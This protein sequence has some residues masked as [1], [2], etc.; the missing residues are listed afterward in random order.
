MAETGSLVT[1]FVVGLLGGVHCIGM[2]G[3][4]VSTLTLS[5]PVQRKTSLGSLF[6]FQ[7]AYNSG[8]ILGYVCVGALLGALG[9]LLLES[10]HLG[11]GQRVLYGIAALFMILLGLYLGGWWPGLAKIERLGV[12]VWRL[13]KPIGR[14]FLPVRS[15]WQAIAVGFVWAWIPCGLLYSVL[16]LAVSVGSAW[17]GALLMLAFG[18]GTLPNMLGIGML[19]GAAARVRDQ[20]WL[21]R[22]A[23]VIVFA[24][25]I[26]ALWQL[27]AAS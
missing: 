6:G 23:G 19:A 21:R 14:R 16:V 17:H 3:G 7:L 20:A 1:A 10:G 9:G 15:H 27:F 26:S 13:I 2:C 5:L 24:F 8:R 22:L 18:L 11:A 4:I 12:P 25:G